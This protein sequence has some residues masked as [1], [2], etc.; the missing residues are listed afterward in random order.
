MSGVYSSNTGENDFMTKNSIN[1][2]DQFLNQLRKERLPA[3][4]V[5]T[6]ETTI[7]GVV[8]G[9]DNFCIFL[10]AEKPFLIYKHAISTISMK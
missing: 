3:V 6:D 1:V 4:I 2:Q 8:K 10:E 7:E 5:L 9:F